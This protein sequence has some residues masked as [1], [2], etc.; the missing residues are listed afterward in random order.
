ME[1]H[2]HDP[3]KLVTTA[4]PNIKL[5][6]PPSADL[7]VGAYLL[8]GAL[9]CFLR[10]LVLYRAPHSHFTGQMGLGGE[11][12][13]FALRDSVTYHV[14]HCL[15]LHRNTSSEHTKTQLLIF[16]IPFRSSV[17]RWRSPRN[18]A[19]PTLPILQLTRLS[20]PSIWL[21]GRMHQLCANGH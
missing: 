17:I 19:Y 7:V 11:I 1:C 21:W 2:V 9:A 16:L 3:S 6:V 13:K 20:A 12:S 14:H 18:A 10:A 15:F 8:T 4:Q 5:V